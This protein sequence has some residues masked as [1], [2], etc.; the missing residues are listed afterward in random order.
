M[1][2]S[3]PKYLLI[4]EESQEFLSKGC[5][6]QSEKHEGRSREDDNCPQMARETEADG[7][8]VLAIDL[9]PQS[10]LSQS[11]LGP[12]DYVRHIRNNDPTVVQILD[13]YIPASGDS[14]SPKPINVNDIILRGVGYRVNNRLDLIVSRLELSRTL[15]K[16]A[17]MERRLARANGQVNDQYDLA[18]IDCEPTESILTEVAYFAS[19]YVVVPVKPEFMA[20]ISLPLLARYL[21]EFG[22]EN[23]DHELEI[24]GLAL[25]EQSE[26]ASNWEKNR[27]IQEV[28]DVANE[29]GW[30]IFE[31]EIPYSR[32]Y[33]KAARIGQPL[34]S[35]PY[36]QRD[37]IHG[38][39]SLKDEILAAV[40]VSE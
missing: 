33:A 32:S 13:G 36:A 40:G 39:R 15:K 12:K 24:A 26:Y 6:D 20:T 28:R 27:S 18:V 34:S 35:T 10:N 9:D 37:R 21:R 25:N 31:Y 17:G 22:L 29:H 19:R 2:L 4:R 16:P 1:T 30:R 7:L 5:R 11:I 8:R 14:G 3:H 23:E 38:F